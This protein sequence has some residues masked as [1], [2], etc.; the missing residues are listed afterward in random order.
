MDLSWNLY[1][2]RSFWL[3]RRDEQMVLEYI[4]DQEA[5]AG[6]AVLIGRFMQHASQRPD[7]VGQRLDLCVILLGNSLQLLLGLRH[8]RLGI[9]ITAPR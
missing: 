3:R 4:R 7:D 6:H 9:L 8:S 2:T 1:T 5:E